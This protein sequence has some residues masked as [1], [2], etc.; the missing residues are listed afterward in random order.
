[1]NKSKFYITEDNKYRWENNFMMIEYSDPSIQAFREYEQIDRNG[2]MYYYYT[3]S[4]YKK[5]EK[6]V[7]E[8]DIDSEE[9][10]IDYK[11]VSKRDT[12]DFPSILEFEYLLKYLLDDDVRIDGQRNEMSSGDIRYS[13]TLYTDG[14]AC[15]DMYEITKNV[16]KNNKNERYTL[17]IGTT[18]DGDG[19]CNSTGLRTPYLNRNDIIDLLKCVSKFINYSIKLNN[20]SAKESGKEYKIIGDKIYRYYYDYDNNKIDYDK[21]DSIFIVGDALDDLTYMIGV[22]QNEKEYGITYTITKIEDNL[23]YVID[24]YTKE[25]KSFNIKDLRYISCEVNKEK[26]KYNEVQIAEDFIN[27]LSNKEKHDFKHKN[28]DYLYN[29]YGHAI[30]NRTIMCL[31]NHNY[32][33]KRLKNEY[34]YEA[35]EPV[36]KCVIKL[37]KKSL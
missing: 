24:D 6:Y 18:F 36:I 2:I 28:I 21:I 35:I 37:I 17:Y 32:E 30:C 16:D 26:T 8:D 10:F 27:I 7:N 19:D 31:E 22:S 4:I 25:E 9:T 20:D 29:K 23:I 33:T 3:L 11:L 12:Y 15:D 34:G 5:V 14:F 13:K 1:M